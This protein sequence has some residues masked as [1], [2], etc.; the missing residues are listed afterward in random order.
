MITP[1]TQRLHA[2]GPV[3]VSDA[4]GGD[5]RPAALIGA[6]PTA[7]YVQLDGGEVIAVLARDAVRLP[8]GLTLAATSSEQPLDRWAGPVRVGAGRVEIGEVSVSV[9]RLVAVTAPSGSRPDGV[10]V[11][12]ACRRLQSRYGCHADLGPAE[13]LTKDMRETARALAGRLPGVGPGLTPSGDDTLAGY[14]VGA[15]RFGLRADRLRAVVREDSPAATT[16]LSAALLLCAARGETIPQ[17]RGLFAAVC[18][19]HPSLSHVD[20]ALDALARVGHGSGA[21]LAAGAMAQPSWQYG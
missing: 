2:A 3:R 15:W 11:A 8:L 14:L 17:V 6:F 7:L 9:S 18:E 10:A 19:P 4:L 20:E 12:R 5:L 16:A 1:V 13:D 21:A